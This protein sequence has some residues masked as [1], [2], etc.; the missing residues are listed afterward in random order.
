MSEDARRH[1]VLVTRGAGVNVGFLALAANRCCGNSARGLSTIGLACM[2]HDAPSSALM[3]AN[4]IYGYDASN[5]RQGE[6][7]GA[8]TPPMRPGVVGSSPGADQIAI[9][10][11][12]SKQPILGTA[13][14]PQNSFLSPC[15][16]LFCRISQWAF[17]IGIWE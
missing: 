3:T 15:V 2:A 11:L 13:C 14:C 10:N 4:P 6:S 5:E 16:D 7:Q 8:C 9:L 12:P 17:D 1:T